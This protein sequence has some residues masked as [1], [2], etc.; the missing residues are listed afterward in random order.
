MSSKVYVC[1]CCTEMYQSDGICRDCNEAL[2][3]VENLPCSE[4]GADMEIDAKGCP[5]CGH[6]NETIVSKLPKAKE[7]NTALQNFDGQ[8]LIDLMFAPVGLG[9]FRKNYGYLTTGPNSEEY[10]TAIEKALEKT[11]EKRITLRLQ[12]GP[13]RWALKKQGTLG[14][15]FNIGIDSIL[16]AAVY[17]AVL[18]YVIGSHRSGGV[19]RNMGLGSEQIRGGFAMAWFFISYFVYTALPEAILGSTVGGLICRSAVVDDYG[20]YLSLGQA[21]ARQITKFFSPIQ[22]FFGGDEDYE[23][24]KR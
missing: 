15:L 17:F 18:V 14:R 16:W 4:C 23:V 21:L 2:V 11:S 13:R 5:K 1:A 19:L 22:L 10:I 24:V 3:P 12:G 8:V 6:R 20:N 9:K 7:R